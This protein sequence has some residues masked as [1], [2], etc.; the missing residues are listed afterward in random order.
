[1]IQLN[2][3]LNRDPNTQFGISS[4]DQAVNEYVFEDAM[5]QAET[6]SE[7]LSLVSKNLDINA[8]RVKEVEAS[9]K[10]R[11]NLLGTIGYVL[12]NTNAGLILLNQNLGTNIGFSAVWNLYD[13]GQNK[14][15]TEIA[16]YR[17][18]GLFAQRDQISQT[19]KSQLTSAFQ[20][21]QA[22][23]DILILEENNKKIAEEN[24]QIA[25]EKFLLGA[26]TILEVNDAQERNNNAANRH[27]NAL[28]NV[29]FAA[30]EIE[31]VTR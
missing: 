23:R 9:N 15:Q 2:L 20:Q 5:K 11:V 17:A 12:S 14:R 3:L 31:R 6:N 21:W 19:I 7:E 18:K 24:L 25:Q 30:L 27:L 4:F 26:S 1:M 10:P 8:L 13:G 16:K 22:S 28:Y 29:K